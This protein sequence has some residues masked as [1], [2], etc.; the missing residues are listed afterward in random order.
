MW[1]EDRIVSEVIERVGT[2]EWESLQGEQFFDEESRGV[3]VESIISSMV[4]EWE[5]QWIY[6]P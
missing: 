1:T 6:L 5:G 2:M 3:F 4:E